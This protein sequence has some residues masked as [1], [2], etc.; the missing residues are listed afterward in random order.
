MIPDRFPG[1]GPLAG[2]EAVLR[3]TPAD[4]NLIVA[5][6][7]PHLDAALLEELFRA[8]G[9]CNVAAYEDGNFEPLCAVYHRRCHAAVLAALEAGVRRLKDVLPSLALRYVRVDASR[10]IPNLNT[11]EDLTRYQNG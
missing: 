9:D 3:T 7:M 6:D 10:P 5:C 1:A 4:W 2:I 11:P 8:G